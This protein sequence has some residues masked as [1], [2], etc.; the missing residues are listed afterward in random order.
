[1]IQATIHGLR[2]TQQ[3][4]PNMLQPPSEDDK[5]PIMVTNP[6]SKLLPHIRLL[7]TSLLDATSQALVDKMTTNPNSRLQPKLRILDTR[8]TPL[9]SLK[10]TFK[11]KKSKKEDLTRKWDLIP[12]ITALNEQPKNSYFASL[13]YLRI[14]HE[15]TFKQCYQSN[16]NPRGQ[17]TPTPLQFS[18]IPE[19]QTKM[20][21]APHFEREHLT[22][23]IIHAQY[24]L[25]TKNPHFELHPQSNKPTTLSIQQ[26]TER[27]ETP[28]YSNFSIQNFHYILLQLTTF[29]RKHRLPHNFMRAIIATIL[30]TQFLKYIFNSFF[31]CSLDTAVRFIYIVTYP[32]AVHKQLI[33]H[34]LKLQRKQDE[35][36]TEAYQNFLTILLE[37]SLE[38]PEYLRHEMTTLAME[39]AI[40]NLA[41]PDAKAMVAHAQRDARQKD[42]LPNITFLLKLA[43]QT[44]AQFSPQYLL[45][46]T[47][48]QEREPITLTIHRN[49]F[50]KNFN[51]EQ[52]LDIQKQAY[53]VK[54]NYYVQ[55]QRTE[56]PQVIPDTGKRNEQTSSNAILYCPLC[57]KIDHEWKDCGLLRVNTIGNRY[58]MNFPH[59]QNPNPF[60][61]QTDAIKELS[62]FVQR[63]TMSTAT[64]TFLANT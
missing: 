50:N 26:V 31:N 64:T 39:L 18:L 49:L 48:D 40:M 11:I 30:P 9:D 21:K 29:A 41:S 17:I 55:S 19:A 4:Q 51:L 38:I 61:P 6:N 47:F 2:K 53:E 63:R 13:T 54:I 8:K 1:M 62:S 57:E 23:E 46:V 56:G 22:N 59:G 3:S 5:K 32:T 20:F 42:Q 12:W 35:S 44:E 10:Q 36:I 37:G 14:A 28:L 43:Y 58:G 25:F 16:L 27:L 24:L 60:L 7:D 33:L 45:N 15:K 34:I 52:L